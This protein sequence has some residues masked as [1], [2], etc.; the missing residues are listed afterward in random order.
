MFK[1]SYSY[2][3]G[4]LLLIF[5]LVMV[6]WGILS[7]AMIVWNMSQEEKEKVFNLH[8]NHAACAYFATIRVDVLLVILGWKTSFW[9]VRKL[10]K[11][12]SVWKPCK[13][14]PTS[15][16]WNVFQFLL[17]LVRFCAL[18][19]CQIVLGSTYFDMCTLDEYYS[20]T[21]K[22]KY[23]FFSLSLSISLRHTHTHT[24]THTHIKIAH[25]CIWCTHTPHVH[26]LKH[27]CTL[28]TFN[29]LPVRCNPHKYWI[30]DTAISETSNRASVKIISP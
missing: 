8:V 15:A 5:L 1:E 18:W 17:L 2:D 23:V 28:C 4:L 19:G 16:D 7:P 10:L 21:W 22:D 12:A 6:W 27:V 20:R 14:C 29:L 25:T 13:F 26:T 3:L 30:L 9:D 24:H 11:K